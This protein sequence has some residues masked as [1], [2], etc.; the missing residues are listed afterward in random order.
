M[1]V[2]LSRSYHENILQ[3]SSIHDKAWA[4]VVPLDVTHSTDH[5]TLHAAFMGG[6]QGI[7]LTPGEDEA[8][9]LLT[10]IRSFSVIS[11]APLVEES[12]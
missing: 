5:V 3:I 11:C 8:H 6:G 10:T 2:Q 12:H 1:T 7:V 4:A 9:P